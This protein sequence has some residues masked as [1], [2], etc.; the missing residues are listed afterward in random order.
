M[1]V[2]VA[3]ACDDQSTIHSQLTPRRLPVLCVCAMFEGLT[4]FCFVFRFDFCATLLDFTSRIKRLHSC[5]YCADVWRVLAH[6]CSEYSRARPL[7]ARSRHVIDSVYMLQFSFSWH[8]CLLGRSAVRAQR[9]LL[10]QLLGL[11]VARCA[12]VRN[13]SLQTSLTE[14]TESVVSHYRYNAGDRRN[15]Y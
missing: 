4:E 2:N 5:Y 14:S 8:A 1:T 11:F 13:N 12:L 6:F 7:T 3:R 15:N 9:W 10:R